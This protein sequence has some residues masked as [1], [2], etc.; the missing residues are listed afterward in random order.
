M[1]CQ[2]FLKPDRSSSKR[3]KRPRVAG[4]IV[5]L[6]GPDTVVAAPDGRAAIAENAPPWLATAGS[7][8]VLAGLVGGAAGAGHAGLRGGGGGGLAAWRSRHRGRSRPD[9]RGSARDAAAALSA[10]VRKLEARSSHLAADV[11]LRLLPTQMCAP[12]AAES[13][14][15]DGSAEPWRRDRH[16]LSGVR[17][18]RSA[19]RRL[20]LSQP[21]IF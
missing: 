13:A 11:R 4:A 7:G 1:P 9:R 10:T 14:A 21:A 8:D 5:L 18:L 20:F 17:P 15:L 3:A 16:G 12:R 19:G 6:K 2:A